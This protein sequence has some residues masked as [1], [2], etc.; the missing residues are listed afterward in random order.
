MEPAGGEN[1]AYDIIIVGAGAAGCVLAGRL[2]EVAVRLVLLIE[3]GP[4]APAGREHPEISDPYPISVH[5][6]RFAWPD[7][8][9]ETGVDRGEGKP[10]A[11]RR[12]LQWYGV[13]GG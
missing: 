13:G 9:A 10:R 12:F 5:N 11:S 8:I 4:D 3:A 6:P 2:S 1:D 7:L